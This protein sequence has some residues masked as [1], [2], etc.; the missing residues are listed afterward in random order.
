MCN[1]KA[2]L[3]DFRKNLGQV[4]FGIEIK[5]TFESE[6]SM[7]TCWRVMKKIILSALCHTVHV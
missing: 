2:W 3:E 4:F 6:P 5:I 1:S 7:L